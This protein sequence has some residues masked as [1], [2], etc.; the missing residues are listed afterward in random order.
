MLALGLA[1]ST[2]WPALAQNTVTYIVNERAD[3][4]GDPPRNVVFAEQYISKAM[5]EPLVW[6][7]DGRTGESG[8]RPAL[9]TSWEIVDDNTWRFFLREGVTF[10]NG[11]PFNAAAV[12]F[13][14]ERHLDPDFPSTDKF[15][16]VPITAVNV[17]DD[18]T[19]EFVTETPVPILP[20]RLSRNGAFIMAPGHYADLPLDQ[21]AVSPVGTGPYK[22][23]EFRRDDRVIMSKN[24]DWWGWDDKSNIDTLVIR[25]IP[26]M[27]T[28]FSEVLSGNA[29]IVRITP[30]LADTAASQDGVELIVAPTTV[31]AVVIFNMDMYPELKDPRV[32]VALNHAVDREAIIDA[33]AFGSQELVS[34][35][36]I[37][38][39]NDDPN[40]EPYAY[41][42]DRAR[43]L[44]AEAGF[45]DGFDIATID[46]MIP[47][48]FQFS[49]AVA[50]Y[51]SMVGVNVGE[52]RQL[53][54]S[55]M[56]ERWAQRTL[57]VAGYAWSAGENTPE[58]DAWAVH[59]DRQTNSTHWV[60]PDFLEAYR[61]LTQTVNPERR[62]ELSYQM[63]GII[64]EDPPWVPLFRV[65]A[66]YAV[67]ERIAGY[68]PHPSLLVEDWGAIYV[69]K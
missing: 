6:D 46:V 14:I 69:E 29:D 64:Y 22:L 26:E 8:I 9:A 62:R 53:E 20:E 16:D 38:P 45:P 39:P 17:I 5:F 21:A 44:L 55:V 41:D 3:L 32:R 42:P 27:S 4:I 12:K 2:A 25:M 30:D 60:R 51:W 15:R 19:V 36:P 11:E 49:E 43:K 10:H 67:N 35:T 33:F 58:T 18:Y 24:E 66:A 40:L 57:S 59:D 31:R 48:A 61:E 56:R 23:K 47:D 65:P 37:N 7:F 13:S 34:K 68:S 28:A 54:A 63:Q 50:A 52:V 1:A